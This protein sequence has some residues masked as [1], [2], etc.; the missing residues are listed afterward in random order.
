VKVEIGVKTTA[1]IADIRGFPAGKAANRDR[2]IRRIRAVA[3]GL[4]ADFS[5]LTGALEL[6]S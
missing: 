2:Q 3:Q 4:S 5:D 1:G 6:G